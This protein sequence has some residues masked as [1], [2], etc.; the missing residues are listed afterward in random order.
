MTQSSIARPPWNK[1]ANR[2]L[3]GVLAFTAAYMVPSI[4][5]ALSIG[6]REFLFYIV[7]MFAL[8]AASVI[9]YLRGGLGIGSLWGLAVLGLLHVAG[10]LA[11]VPTT[12]PIDGEVRVLYSWWIIPGWLKYDQVVHAFGH[13][14]LTWICWLTLRRLARGGHIKP[15]FGILVVCAAASM[16]FGALNEIVEYAATRLYER[17]NVGGYENTCLDLLANL[18]GA[19][20]AAIHIRI[21]WRETAAIGPNPSLPNTSSTSGTQ[22]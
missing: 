22:P 12:W 17:T 18:V 16:G 2:R 19:I 10:G 1:A 7:V 4:P 11:R 20:A 5:W 21:R 3:A 14:I 15:T 8:I 13:G 9:A 6:N